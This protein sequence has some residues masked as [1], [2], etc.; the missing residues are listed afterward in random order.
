MKYKV[1]KGKTWRRKGGTMLCWEKNIAKRGHSL[2]K[3]P[4]S[5]A[6]GPTPRI[7]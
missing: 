1:I 7:A 3:N 2:C 4:E 5:E 6:C